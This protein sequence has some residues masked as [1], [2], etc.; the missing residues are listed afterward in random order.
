MNRTGLLIALAVAAVT[1]LVFGIFPQLDLKLQ[2]PW[3]DPARLGFWT[4]IDPAWLWVRQI[5]VWIVTAIAVPAFLALIVKLL[6]PRTRLL[7]PGRAIILMIGTLALGPGLITNVILKDNWGRPRPIDVTQ[8]GGEEH[9]RAWWDPRGECVKNCSFVAGEPSGAFWT[10]APAALTPPAWRALAYG[11]ALALGAASSFVRMTQ[12][13]HFFSD[14]VFAGVFT[15]LLIWTAHGILYRWR[16]RL[17]D[18]QVEGAL[19]RV[20]LPGYSLLERLFA[21]LTRT[22]SG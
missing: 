13:G 9:F 4:R 5:F 3:F 10:L 21:R 2:E 15:F 20:A 14:C 7:I 22:R 19:E 18:E 8:F 12:G 11:A 17:T 1:G 16:T 6:L